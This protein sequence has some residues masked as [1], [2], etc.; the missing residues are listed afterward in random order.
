MMGGDGA[1]AVVFGRDALSAF[2]GASAPN[3]KYMSIGPN[4]MTAKAN[5][6]MVRMTRG[7]PPTEAQANKKSSAQVRKI[8]PLAISGDT[9]GINDLLSNKT[10][11]IEHG[12]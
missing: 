12:Q 1:S 11:P 5:R 2:F 8:S 9:G 10:W 4:S 3:R 7:K 6:E